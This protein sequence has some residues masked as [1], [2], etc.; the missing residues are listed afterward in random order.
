VARFD[1]AKWSLLG[2]AGVYDAEDI[3]IS[4]FGYRIKL[5]TDE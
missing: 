1:G 5:P 3:P 2:D 4:E